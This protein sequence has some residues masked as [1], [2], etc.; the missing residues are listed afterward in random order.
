MKLNDVAK[1]LV[2][3]LLIF[4]ARLTQGN[5]TQQISVSFVWEKFSK[6]R[7][8]LDAFSGYLKKF[9]FLRKLHEYERGRDEQQEAI[10]G[11]FLRTSKPFFFLTQYQVAKVSISSF[12]DGNSHFNYFHDSSM[13]NVNRGNSSI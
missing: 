2:V 11:N 12:I 5:I 4:I 7:L 3:I 13:R 8:F 10:T 9:R 1:F 6:S